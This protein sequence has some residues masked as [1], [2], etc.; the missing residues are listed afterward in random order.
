MTSP[1]NTRPNPPAVDP[2]TAPLAVVFDCDGVLLD[3]ES[4]WAEVQAEIFRMY[5]LEYGPADQQRLM[6][7]SAADVAQE[8][9][10]LRAETREE[11]TVTV[12]KVRARILEVE[13]ELL[14]GRMP[15][16][17]GALELVRRA[18]RAVPTAVASNSTSGI[19]N[20]KMTSTG[21]A[22][23]V[24]TWVSSDDVARGKPAPDMYLEAARRLGTD[25]QRCLAVEDSS[26]GATAALEAGMT[27]VGLSHDGAHVPSSLLITGLQKPQLM[28]LL[29]SWGW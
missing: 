9:T 4:A 27:V 25:P 11:G 24:Q 6:G 7:W 12:D 20:T 22:D 26:A 8:V 1:E 3:T 29:E 14:T 16:I 15:P 17:A 23:H 13:A 5:G 21:I 2:R 28:K 10:R 19:L 18:S